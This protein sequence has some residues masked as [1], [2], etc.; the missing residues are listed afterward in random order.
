MK[1]YILITGI[2]AAGLF[3][4]SVYAFWVHPEQFKVVAYI[5]MFVTAFFFIVVIIKKVKDERALKKKLNTV[6]DDT[7]LNK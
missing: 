2:V 6:K 3:L 4:Y 5:F 1:Y 7:D